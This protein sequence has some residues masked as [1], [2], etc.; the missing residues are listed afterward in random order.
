RRFAAHGVE[1]TYPALY[2]RIRI[3]GW[4]CPETTP[5]SA[6]PG[7]PRVPGREADAPLRDRDDAAPAGE[8]RERQAELRLA[9]RRRRRT[10][11]RR[12]D[13][14]GRDVARRPAPGAHHLPAA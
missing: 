9:L 8:A 10:R 3:Y 1:P 14:A 2:T 4:E 11:P 6:R 13:R 5:Q 7:R 12:A